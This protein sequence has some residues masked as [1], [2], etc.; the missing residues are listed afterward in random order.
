MVFMC[1]TVE[2]LNETVEKELDALPVDLKA[3][4]IRVVELIEIFGLESVGRPHIRHLKGP[5]WEMRMKGKSGIARSIYVTA[6]GKR[7]VVVR[8]FVKKTQKTPGREIR[9]ALER[10]KEV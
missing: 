4:F 10:T 7:V 3:R 1:W 8:A 2:I 5:L 6:K 9:L